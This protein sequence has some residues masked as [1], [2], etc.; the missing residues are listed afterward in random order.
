MG[1]GKWLKGLAGI[2]SIIA[3]PFTGGTSLAWLP[4]ALG[5]A[6]LAGGML[7]NTKGAR[8]G[9]VS[10]TTDPAFT[11]LRDLLISRST[12]KL[13]SPT[14]LPPGYENQGISNI[15]S[16]HDL[17]GQSLQNKLT[18]RGLGGSPNESSVL[19]KEAIGRGGDISRFSNSIP[20]LELDY[21]NRDIDQATNLL[22]M[23][24]G[25][26]TV[27]PGS[28]LGGGLS[29][30]SD[31]LGYLYA[32]G[33]FGGNISGSATLPQLPPSARSIPPWLIPQPGG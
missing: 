9:T 16:I 19:T 18:Q 22:G 1:F 2:G 17:I 31:L 3:A 5:G 21:Q 15:N 13:N 24:M 30:A 20:L 29:Q 7:E 26:E 11:N 6:S 33:A 4:A 28:A 12:S 32:S 23:G 8:T 25:K 27:Y 10:P 14:S